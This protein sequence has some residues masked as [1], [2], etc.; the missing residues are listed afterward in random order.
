VDPSGVLNYEQMTFGEFIAWFCR[1]SH[2][3]MSIKYSGA[4][5]AFIVFSPNVITNVEETRPLGEVS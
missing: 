5:G 1:Y 2:D 4:S 3:A